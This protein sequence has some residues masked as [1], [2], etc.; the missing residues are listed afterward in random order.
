MDVSAQLG[1]EKYAQLYHLSAVNDN[2]LPGSM[3]VCVCV[4]LYVCVCVYVCA[5][6]CLCSG[7]S[8]GDSLSLLSIVLINDAII[9]VG[10]NDE[11]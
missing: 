2:R 9:I 4:G 8:S 1:P 11:L 5:C 6:V 10:R 3:T 7:R